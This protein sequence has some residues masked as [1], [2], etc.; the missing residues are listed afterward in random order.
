MVRQAAG[1]EFTVTVE[2]VP[3]VV[4]SQYRKGNAREV[5]LV[6]YRPGHVLRHVPVVLTE[7]GFKPKSARLYSPDHE[8]ISLPVSRYGEGWMTLVPE[9]DIYGVLV[10][11]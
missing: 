7:Q 9:L 11:E 5:H 8:P 4:A 3:W 1:G 2:S 10:V 6:N